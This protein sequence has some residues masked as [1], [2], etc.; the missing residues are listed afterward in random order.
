MDVLSELYETILRRR[1]E[2]EEGSYTAYLFEKGLDKILKKLGEESAETIIAA[3]NLR[4][5]SAQENRGE[6]VGEVGDLLYHLEV[7]CAELG[8]EPSEVEA[9]LRERAKKSGNLKTARET[10]KNS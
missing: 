3:K 7:L 10:D 8:I 9:L 5:N 6:F 1:D 2:K 4:T